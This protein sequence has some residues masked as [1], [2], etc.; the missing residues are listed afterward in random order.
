MLKQRA[1]T[2]QK[3]VDQEHAARDERFGTCLAEVKLSDAERVQLVNLWQPLRKF[4][5]K[6]TGSMWANRY[7]KEGEMVCIIPYARE[8]EVPFSWGSFA[9]TRYEELRNSAR[10]SDAER[11]LLDGL[12]ETVI[13]FCFCEGRVRTSKESGMQGMLVAEKEV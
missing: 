7:R 12:K 1:D 10:F 2:L 4:M 5:K 13:K 11:L 8:M 3:L 9:E 6:Q